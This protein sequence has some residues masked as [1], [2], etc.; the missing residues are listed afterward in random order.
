MVDWLGA[1]IEG[2]LGI[3]YRTNKMAGGWYERLGRR[4]AGFGLVVSGQEAVL[5]RRGRF[6][7]GASKSLSMNYNLIIHS[8][9]QTGISDLR[10]GYF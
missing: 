1:D 10:V 5:R 8:I 6:Q 4:E 2:F 7:G 9:Q 3:V